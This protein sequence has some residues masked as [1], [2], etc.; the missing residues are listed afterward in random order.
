MIKGVGEVTAKRITD[1]FGDDTLRF[2]NL[3]PSAFKN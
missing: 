3:N 1:T 2:Y